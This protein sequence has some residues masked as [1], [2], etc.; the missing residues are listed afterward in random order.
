MQQQLCPHAIAL[1][2]PIKA[3]VVDQCHA[4]LGKV[5]RMEVQVPLRHCKIGYVEFQNVADR[6]A[7]RRL[8]DKSLRYI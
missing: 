5:E 4:P 2:V 3:V 1:I 7:K 6:E 8:M